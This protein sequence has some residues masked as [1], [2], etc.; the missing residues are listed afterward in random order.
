MVQMEAG[1]CACFLFFLF[2]FSLL[3]AMLFSYLHVVKR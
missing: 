1:I 2:F 3:L